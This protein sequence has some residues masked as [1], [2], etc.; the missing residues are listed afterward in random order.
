MGKTISIIFG[1]IVGLV[2]IALIAGGGFAL[3]L[4]SKTDGEGYINSNTIEIDRTSHAAV[5]GP[6]TM[7]EVAVRVVKII[8]IASDWRVQGS[9]N[10]PAKGI[11]IGVAGAADF[12]TYFNDVSYDE[13]DIATAG[14]LNFQSVEFTNHAGSSTPAAPTSQTFWAESENGS[15]TETVEWRVT[16]GSNM[17]VLMND[18]GSAGIDLDAVISVNVGTGVLYLGIG[19]LV[20]GILMLVPV[21]FL[22][23]NALK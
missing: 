16:A 5:I 12:A 18:D 17:L 7:N 9:S 1:I 20:V 15:G 11:F 8:G 22:F 6:L 14:W 13:M 10:D 2:S 19:L 3:W 4:N 21:F 23:K